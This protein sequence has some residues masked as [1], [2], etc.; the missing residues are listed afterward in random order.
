MSRVGSL[1]LALVVATGCS[2]A[3]GTEVLI[4][5]PDHGAV[6]DVVEVAVTDHRPADIADQ[7]LPS[8]AA[9]TQSPDDAFRETVCST[10]CNC[11]GHNEVLQHDCGLADPCWTGFCD[12]WCLGDSGPSDIDVPDA[13]TILDDSPVDSIEVEASDP[14]FQ[15]CIENGEKCGPS[16]CQPSSLELAGIASIQAYIESIVWPL[17]RPACVLSADFTVTADLALDSSELV[18]KSCFEWKKVGRSYF[19]TRTAP[20]GVVCTE[21]DS[22]YDYYGLCKTVTIVSGTTLRLRPYIIATPGLSTRLLPVVGLIAACGTACR[23]TEVQC[24][25]GT[26][27]LDAQSHCIG[28]LGNED[29]VCV[30]AG[31]E[32]GTECHFFIADTLNSGHCWRDRCRMGSDDHP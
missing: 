12:W 25:D 32:P 2:S 30:C 10:T 26:C 4:G 17:D 7:E 13:G 18:G 23:E 1:F 28:C 19:E 31:R 16:S 3:P 11:C 29:P 6:V 14:G 22:L 20:L 15:P 9:D 27:W 21:P 24:A 5:D 8:D